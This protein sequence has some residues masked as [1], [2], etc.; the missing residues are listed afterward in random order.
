MNFINWWLIRKKL[1]N[2]QL[3][4]LDADGVLTDG[5]L[6][7]DNQGQVLKRFDVRDGIGL[8]LLQQAGLKIAIISGGAKGALEKRADQLDIKHCITETK[9]K[10]IE[11]QKLQQKLGI[12]NA[13]TAFIGDDINDL[14][15]KSSI[16]LFLS[17]A[18]ACT[19]VH[20]YSDA[21]LSKNG[22]HGAL[23]ELAEKI[24]E[25]RGELELINSKG[26]RDL[27]H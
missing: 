27:N 1:R 10:N 2:I 6:W 25:S 9:D 5:G 16:G 23:R 26:L 12:S 4:V 14:V 17:P 19:S 21:V 20:R 8:R 3:L 24:L 7:F 15:V 22:G 13:H 18:D 11:I